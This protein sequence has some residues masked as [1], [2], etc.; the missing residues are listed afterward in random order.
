MTAYEPV[1]GLEVHAELETHSKMFCGCAV[2]DST[3]GEPNRAVCPVCL[4]MPGALPVINQQAV[5]FAL[6][7]G[8]ALHCE[9][10][11]FNQFARKSYFYPDLPKGYQISQFEY[12][13][14]INGWLDIDLP[15]GSTKRIGI[16][17]AHLE[18]DAGKL[19][20]A[21]AHSLVDLNRAGVPLLEIV[22]EADMRS[23]DEAEAYA[24]KLRT[25]L[26]YLGVNSGDMSKG[27]LRFES[28]V[29]VRP[30][31]S[32]ELRTRT[33]IKN[34]NSIRALTRGTEY[35]IARQAKVW[36][37]GGE[38]QQA[39]MGWDEARQVTVV[40]RVKESSDDYR[41]FPEP[42]LPIVEISREWVERVRAALPELPD[43]KEARFIEALGLTRYD[44]VVLV[45]ERAVAEYFEAAV[46]AGGDAKQVAN[47]ITGDLFRL[48]NQEGR[49]REDIG[50]IKLTPQ[51]LA[52][53]VT[54]V[55]QGTINH[56]VAKQ[57]ME[58]IY[59]EGGD[60]AALVEQRGLAQVSDESVL[61][62]AVGATLDENPDEV[63]RYLAGEDKL[64]KFLMGK[65]MRA[66][67]GKGDAQAIQ[68]L[69]AEQLEARR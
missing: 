33:E 59:A 19:T 67:R 8:L 40:Q 37:S 15:D 32:D 61:A 53:L 39:T 20:H 41:Y 47:Y 13:L 14:A 52:K 69:L 62:E 2:V 42:D 18:E 29:S 26:Q 49:E 24:R 46:Q 22:S 36:D 16:R 57:L 48:M 27:V 31:G 54:L 34:L 44:A 58:T 68:R 28:N 45:A 4:G 51:A 6:M 50:G 35:E 65:V 12:P 10:P 43:A 7:V 30:V 3:T 56:N 5:E 21:G 23:A 63:A 1:I 55:Q 17:R 64:I 11:A 9:I 38:V 66:L 25:I 60:P